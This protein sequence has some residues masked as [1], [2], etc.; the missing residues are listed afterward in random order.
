L[1]CGQKYPVAG[2]DLSNIPPRCSNDN[3][4]LKPDFIFFGEGIPA[5]AYQSS[6]NEADKA[7]L[8]ILV[9]TTGEVMPASYVPRQAKKNGCKIIEINPEESLYTRT[10]TNIHIPMKAADAFEKLEKYLF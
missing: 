9:G 10:I 1:N 3:R 4:V 8:F 6:F 7:D 5:D 2:V